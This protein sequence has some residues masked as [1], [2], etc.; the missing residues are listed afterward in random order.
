MFLCICKVYFLWL[1]EKQQI[2]KFPILFYDVI[3]LFNLLQF[4]LPFCFT[5]M[6]VMRHYCK[7]SDFENSDYSF[8]FCLLIS[9]YTLNT[10]CPFIQ[11][12]IKKGLIR[13]FKWFCSVFTVDG[14]DKECDN[15]WACKPIKYSYFCAVICWCTPGLKGSLLFSLIL[16]LI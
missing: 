9:L 13:F 12:V 16:F 1:K 3:Y 2:I 8:S 6:A 10:V 4:I 5:K 7:R 11:T 15:D 14:L